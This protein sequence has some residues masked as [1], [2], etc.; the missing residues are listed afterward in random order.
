MIEVE[1]EWMDEELRGAART[2]ALAAAATLKAKRVA[3]PCDETAAAKA[4]IGAAREA[5]LAVVALVEP[6]RAGCPNEA[7][8]RAAAIDHAESVAR[9]LAPDALELVRY[10]FPDHGSQGND[11][12][13]PGAGR[14]LAALCRC[15]GCTRRLATRQLDAAKVA[16]K[17]DKALA[18]VRTGKATGPLERPEEIGPWLVKQLGGAESA[19]LLSVRRESLVALVQEVR[20]R[21]AK[22]IELQA[23]AHPSPFVGGRAIG[24]GLL[25][26]ADWLA[27]FTL[28]LASDPEALQPERL[29]AAVK[30][31]R[32]AAL[33]TSR[34]TLRL[35]LPDAR[36]RPALIA[37]LQAAAKEGLAAVR[38]VDAASWPEADLVALRTAL[39][40]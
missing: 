9:A 29:A 7:K 3:L 19:A 30:S 20:K 35:P 15:E 32:T 5:K 11:G 31:A 36:E 17:V 1:C 33:P 14:F 25:A 39:A 27:G 2:R 23:L 4:A 21:V 37:A 22:T 6:P 26:L 8:G 34:F 38:V 10:G 13:L 16:A 24:G 40:K 12:A 28:D 18:D